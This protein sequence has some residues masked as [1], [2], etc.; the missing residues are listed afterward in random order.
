MK[1]AGVSIHHDGVLIQNIKTFI[2]LEKLKV[3]T[4]PYF[5]LYE[6]SS[7]QI[8]SFEF[9]EGGQSCK[10]YSDY[11]EGFCDDPNFVKNSYPS[12]LIPEKQTLCL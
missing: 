1:L 8:I 3:F 7:H 12:S 10:Y 9:R 2:E 4:K 11:F 5:Y 6:K